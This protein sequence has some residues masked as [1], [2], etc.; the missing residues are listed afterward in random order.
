MKKKLFV[1]RDRRYWNTCGW[2][3]YRRGAREM[4]TRAEADKFASEMAQNG[5][6]C[7]VVEE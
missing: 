1:K 6:A 7:A 2:T 3:P 5:T 4:R